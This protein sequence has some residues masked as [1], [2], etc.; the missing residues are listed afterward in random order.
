MGTTCCSGTFVT[1]SAAD[2][3]RV[4]A[5]AQL[6][7]QVGLDLVT[8]QDHPYQPR[9]LDTWTLLSV[10]AARH[11]HG[12]GRAQRRQPPAA[13]AGRPGPRRRQPRPPQRRPGRARPRRRRVLGRDRGDGRPPPDDGAGGSRARGGHRRSSA[14][15]V[16]AEA[17]P[18]G[19]TASTTALAGAKPGPAPAH[20]VGIWLGALQ[21][22][23]ARADRPGSPTGGCPAGPT[24]A[25]DAL[26]EMN[27]R[28]DE[29]AARGRAGAGR[30]CAGSTTSPAAFDRPG[31]GFLGGPADDV[32]R[33]ARRAG[34]ERGHERLHPRS[35]T[36]P[37]TI[38]ALRRRGRARRPG[39]RRAE[40]D[41]AAAADADSAPDVAGPRREQPPAV[42]LAGRSLRRLGVVATPDD[43]VRLSDEPGLGRVDPADRRRR[44]TPTARYTAHEAGAPAS[45]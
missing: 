19:S 34:A 10:I 30:R 45:T 6:T 26:P 11:H 24:S 39:D 35:A 43:G 15:T 14:A 25:P 13:P 20:D 41:A 32:G 5:L 42:V 17:A 2:P 8:V 33:A 21:A 1:P 18:C 29:A 38:C 36:S 4:V 16:D 9:F 40:R 23:D 31:S 44:R 28:I 3:D 27:A 12:A 7:E 37:T 22:A